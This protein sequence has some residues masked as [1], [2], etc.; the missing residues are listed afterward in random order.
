MALTPRS[1]VFKDPPPEAWSP[2]YFCRLT[3]CPELG[4]LRLPF[5]GGHPL[6]QMC[7]GV[8]SS[9]PRFPA[10]DLCE[11]QGPISFGSPKRFVNTWPIGRG[12]LSKRF[13]AAG[14]VKGRVIHPEANGDH[15]Q[16]KV[17]R[18]QKRHQVVGF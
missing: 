9:L 16:G 10:G 4:G 13:D 15:F 17:A 14:I 11:K 2:S 18:S 12:Q 5:L 8:T 6:R 3:H 1:R 7:R